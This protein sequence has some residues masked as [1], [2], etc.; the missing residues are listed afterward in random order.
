M[1]D[2]YLNIPAHTGF[3]FTETTYHDAPTKID[4]AKVKLPLPCAVCITGGGRG[5]GEAY[6]LAFA[7]AGASDIILTARSVNELEEVAGKVQD[8]SDKVNVSVVTCDVSQ[9][10]DVLGL[11]ETIKQKH[12]RLDILINNAGYLDAGWQPITDI[13]VDDWKRVFDVNVNGVF[14]VTRALIPLLLESAKGLK[15][16]I[17][18]SS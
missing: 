17:G 4:P 2:K 14:L 7:K 18:I 9:E 3:F 5:L 6:A 10:K 11:A 13:Q 15:T 1:A 8:I 12:G 16:V